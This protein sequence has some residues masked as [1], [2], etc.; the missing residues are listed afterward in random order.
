MGAWFEYRIM[1]TS[2]ELS[3]LGGGTGLCEQ[4]LT[5]PDIRDGEEYLTAE[6]IAKL[7]IS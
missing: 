7:L 2:A 4:L 3:W 6:Y 5:W 1:S